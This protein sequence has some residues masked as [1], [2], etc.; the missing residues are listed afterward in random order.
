[1][2][3]LNMIE[4]SEWFSE[5]FAIEQKFAFSTDTIEWIMS[6][7]GYQ[8]VTILICMTEYLLSCR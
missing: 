5:K 6:A 8:Y 4:S 1:M 7:F 3:Q 2:D